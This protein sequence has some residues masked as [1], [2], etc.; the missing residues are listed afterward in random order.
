MSL[1]VSVRLCLSIEG[2]S[3]ATTLGPSYDTDRLYLTIEVEI[4]VAAF[5]TWDEYQL[6]SLDAI[7]GFD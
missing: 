5:N 7:A 2:T 1:C 4:V 6:F 3:F